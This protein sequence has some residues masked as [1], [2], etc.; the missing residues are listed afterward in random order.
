MAVTPTSF[1]PPRQAPTSTPP[2]ERLTTADLPALAALYSLYPTGHF[3]PDVLEH[4][5][6]YGIRASERLVAVGGT[7]AIAAPYGLAVLGNIF[8]HPAARG[9]GYAG[10]V[11]AVLVGELFRLGVSDV[12]LNVL[13]DNAPAIRVY[14]RLGFVLAHP[15]LTGLAERIEW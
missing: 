12:V 1:L 11:T 3:R 13:A 15:Y 8:T 4:G 6:F 2:A 5:V 9:R 7:H 14:E 10:A